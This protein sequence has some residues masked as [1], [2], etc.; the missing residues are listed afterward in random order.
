[1]EHRDTTMREHPGA[2]RGKVG[3]V[4]VCV[5]VYQFLRKAL[6]DRKVRPI[7]DRLT[8]RPRTAESSMQALEG[9]KSSG[10]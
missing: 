10:W 2:G 9:E 3:V 1:M 5:C 6:L 7:R 8:P 4:C